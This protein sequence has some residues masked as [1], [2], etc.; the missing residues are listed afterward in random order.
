VLSC[1]K[2]SNDRIFATLSWASY[3]K[4]WPG[5]AESD[6]PAAYIVIMLD[7]RASFDADIDSGI[8]AQTILLGAVERGLGG[9]IVANFKKS[10]LESMLELPDHLTILLVVAL[11]K[12]VETVILEDLPAGGSIMYYRDS[13]QRRHVPKRTVAELVFSVFR[14]KREADARAADSHQA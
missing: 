10:E 2:E 8:A 4:D 3:L 12:P 6:R 1:T 7:R 9:C 13:S 11:G 14:E 5:P